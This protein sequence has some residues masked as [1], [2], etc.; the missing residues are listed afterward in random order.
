MT[1]TLDYFVNLPNIIELVNYENVSVNGLKFDSRKVKEGDIFICLSGDNTD[2]HKYVED[3]LNNGAIAVVSEKKLDSIRV[4]QIIVKSSREACSLLA[5]KYYKN[6]VNKLKKIAV[7][8]TTGKT[9]IAYLIYRAINLCTANKCSL[10]GTSGYYSKDK[11][12]DFS[13][14]GPVTTPEPFE[15]NSFFKRFHDEGCEYV[16][17]EAS[18]FGMAQKRL[19]GIDFDT[20]ILSNISFSHHIKYHGSYEEY[21]KSKVDLFKQVKK[22]SSSVLNSDSE[23]FND[24][25][26]SSEKYITY[27]Y[28]SKSDINIK[29]SSLTDELLNTFTLSYN[30]RVYAGIT[31]LPGLYNLYNIAAAFGAGVALNFD[32]DTFFRALLKVESI[33]GR[34]DLI[35]SNHPSNIIIDKANTPI[36]IENIS[37]LINTSNYKTKIAVFGNV[38][39]GE[40][41]ERIRLAKMLQDLFDMIIITTD[42][43]EFEDPQ[44][45]IDDFLSGIDKDRIIDCIVETNRENAI[46]KAINIGKTGDLLAI[47]GR[48]NQREFLVSGKTL[49]FDD[50]IITR[51]I[52]LDSGYKVEN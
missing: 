18:S 44:V 16:V 5:Q 27:G 48:G 35:S 11:K 49:D 21:I 15:L 19:F 12:L 47:L 52:L 3:A 22:N 50:T 4:P 37:S 46:R 51:K 41:N 20:A 43:P 33:P 23:Y 17:L 24:F 40:R 45:G 29:N 30:G 8:G 34:W 1:F 28:K 2:G 26:N 9:S 39:G 42:D 31:K 36:A 32:H 25:V 6:S 10:I 14:C 38:G 13:L 7:T